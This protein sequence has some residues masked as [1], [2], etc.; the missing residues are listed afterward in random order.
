MGTVYLADTVESGDPAALKIVAAG[1]SHD[2]RFRARFERECALAAS[3]DHPNVVTTLASGETEGN[4][5][6]AME[7]VEGADLREILRR[8]A[9]LEPG[10]ALRPSRTGRG[11]A[12]RGTRAGPRPPRR[13]A[14]QHPRH[15][16][17]RGR[18]RA[19]LRLRSRA[20]HSSVSSLTTDRGFVGTIDYVPPEQIEGNQVDRRSD[21]YSLQPDTRRARSRASRLAPG[22]DLSPSICSGGT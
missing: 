15:G 17:R 2:S 14:R 19:H 8:E 6:L 7:Y 16:A 3:L 20:P 13:Q 10:R 1:P 18:A 22:V 12:R 11:R 4:L 5:Y 9:P 21:L